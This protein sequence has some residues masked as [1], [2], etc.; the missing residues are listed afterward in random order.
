M[1]KAFIYGAR[2]LEKYTDRILV[3]GLKNNSW[4]ISEEAENIVYQIHGAP[5]SEEDDKL[6]LDNIKRNIVKNDS[7]K[8]I[9]LVHRPDEIQLRFPELKDIL[10]T[11]QKPIG[12]TFLGD[13]HVNDSFFGAENLIKRVIPHGF[14]AIS[15][16]LQIEPLVVG[17]HTT[18][19]EMRSIEHIF[20]LLVEVFRKN[21]SIIGYVGGKPKDQLEEGYLKTEWAKL[22]PNVQATFFDA[23]KDN[24]DLSKKNVIFVDSDNVEPEN[25]GLSFNV[26]MYY[27]NDSVRTG[28]SSG[29]VHSSVGVPVILEM[30]G[31]E[32]I[33]DVKVIKVPYS[34]KEDIHS[35]DFKAGADL[36]LKSIEDSSYQE[37][38]KHNLEQSKKFNSTFVGSEYVK[39][40][41]ELG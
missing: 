39:L 18:W 1:N 34:S 35:I 8:R 26:Q 31:S 29:S 17:S 38:L 37:M 30:N 15:E 5:Q 40:F 27:L 22:N 23:H 13:M 6:I 10:Q 2:T 33:E 25:F 41:Q 28:E 20:K 36:I 3:K 24:F 32:I 14:F 11:A 16:K 9:I 4:E 19:G 7:T 21:S 12:L